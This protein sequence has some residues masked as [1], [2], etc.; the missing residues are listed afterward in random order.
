MTHEIKTPPPFVSIM[1]GSASDYEVASVASSVLNRLNIKYEMKV[2]S[3]HR[4]PDIVHSYVRNANSRG[5]SVFIT[6]AGLAN[7]LSGTVAALTHRPVIGVPVSAGALQG[8]DALLSTVQMPPGVPVA[9]VAIDN[10]K[11]AAILA[12][13]ILAVADP[14]LFEE[15]KVYNSELRAEVV[16]RGQEYETETINADWL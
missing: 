5:C 8:Q 4:T 7:H 16:R 2:A 15:I 9:C 11:N 6:I 10:G 12:A 3:A 13:Q 14:D 1:M